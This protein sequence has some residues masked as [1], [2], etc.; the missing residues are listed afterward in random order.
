[1]GGTAPA[2]ADGGKLGDGVDAGTEAGADGSSSTDGAS[3]CPAG[4]VCDDFEGAGTIAWR[5]MMTGNAT[6]GVDAVKPKSGMR[7]L[8]ASRPTA[9]GRE[10]AY[11][12]LTPSGT[13][14]SCDL[15]VFATGSTNG[16]LSVFNFGYGSVEPP[17]TNYSLSMQI[18]GGLAEYGPMG[19]SPAL[20]HDV[21]IAAL[22]FGRWL[23]VRLDFDWT[24]SAAGLT[25]T[26]DGAAQPKFSITPPKGTMP[27]V[28]LGVTY[29]SAVGQGWDVFVDNVVCASN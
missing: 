7:S 11:Y 23:H 6:I 28:Q 17:F 20:Y 22:A 18:G 5:P 9:A 25:V 3:G 26:V 10:L 14:R 8:H 21:H 12:E 16:S 4:A 1:M 27:Y 19:S 24:P 2:A 15:D 13:L 29:Q